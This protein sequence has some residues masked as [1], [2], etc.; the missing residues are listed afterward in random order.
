VK[1][2]AMEMNTTR[3]LLEMIK[4]ALAAG[5]GRNPHLP[6]PLPRKQ[7]RGSVSGGSRVRR[8]ARLDLVRAI[9]G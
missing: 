1:Q 4:A 3:E 2:E 6:S 9:R 7:G 5:Y 8:R